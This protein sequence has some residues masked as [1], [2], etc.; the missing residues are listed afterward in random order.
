MQHC[1]FQHGVGAG[2]V[3]WSDDNSVRLWDLAAETSIGQ[4]NHH[5]DYVR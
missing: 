1:Q 3:S 4:I 2:L 5:S